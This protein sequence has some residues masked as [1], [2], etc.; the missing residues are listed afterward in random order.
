[1]KI[2]KRLFLILAI[3]ALPLYL[4]A[5]VPAKS[6]AWEPLLFL[7]GEWRGEGIAD[8]TN[9]SVFPPSAQNSQGEIHEDHGFLSYDKS[10]KKFI[11][12]QF[13]IEGFVNQYRLDSISPDGLK[14]V[15]ITEA[16]ENIPAGWKAKESYEVISN[17]EFIETFELAAPGKAFEVYSKVRLKRVVPQQ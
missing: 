15:F 14:I 6:K 8:S 9:R 13:H 1:M 2:S 11:M 3:G 5:Q 12:R 7:I 16:I 4:M 10:D 17:D